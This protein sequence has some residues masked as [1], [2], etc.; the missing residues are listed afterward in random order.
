MLRYSLGFLQGQ[1]LDPEWM[2]SPGESD[3]ILHLM[4][5][6]GRTQEQLPVDFFVEAEMRRDSGPAV[7]TS[8]TFWTAHAIRWPAKTQQ[9]SNKNNTRMV[10]HISKED[11]TQNPEATDVS[12]P[13][14][15]SLSFHETSCAAP[16]ESKI[17]LFQNSTASDWR[18]H[19]QLL[20]G[21]VGVS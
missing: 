17:L 21:R 5:P 4:R 20:Q 3:F 15:P 13:L 19:L 18:G 11:H 14:P 8:R 12:P 1:G 10:K 7:C 16:V 6:P 2:K 9:G